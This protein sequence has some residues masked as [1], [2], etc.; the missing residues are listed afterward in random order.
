MYFKLKRFLYLHDTVAC[1]MPVKKGKNQY[2]RESSEWVLEIMSIQ[3]NS[4]RLKLSN[5]KFPN[6]CVS[7]KFKANSYRQ[8]LTLETME[9]KL[10][11]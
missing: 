2:M 5:T 11:C 3:T 10:R 8:L 4:M 7:S 9:S 1:S 6:L